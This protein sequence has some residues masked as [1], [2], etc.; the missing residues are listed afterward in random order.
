M[1]LL[2]TQL[3]VERD[4]AGCFWSDGV[5]KTVFGDGTVVVANFR[6]QP[7]KYNGQLIPARDFI[8]KKVK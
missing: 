3:T 8:I 6:Q 7:Y 1:M 2:V 4:D 5:A